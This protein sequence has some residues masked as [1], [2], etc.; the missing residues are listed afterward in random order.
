MH[1]RI[2]KQTALQSASQQDIGADG[3]PRKP[4]TTQKVCR[5]RWNWSVEQDIAN[6]LQIRP[7]NRHFIVQLL[8]VLCREQCLSSRQTAL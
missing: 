8:E 5:L 1:T 7:G 6:D 2:S 3:R 4:I